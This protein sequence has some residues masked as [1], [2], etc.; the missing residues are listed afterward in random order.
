MHRYVP[1][2]LC[3][4]PLLFVSRKWM[5]FASAQPVWQ[6][7][8]KTP[9]FKETGIQ[10]R[11]AVCVHAC[12]RACECVW[13]QPIS[14]SDELLSVCRQ[15]AGE[16]APPIPQ[17]QLWKEWGR[18]E[19]P[20][21][22]YGSAGISP[23][24]WQGNPFFY[25][26]H[27]QLIPQE[28]WRGGR[29]G[30]NEDVREE[31]GVM[32]REGVSTAAGLKEGDHHRHRL[33]VTHLIQPVHQLFSALHVNECMFTRSHMFPQSIHEHRKR[34]QVLNLKMTGEDSSW[35]RFLRKGTTYES[36]SAHVWCQ[37]VP[38]ISKEALCVCVSN[39]P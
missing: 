39:L 2:V 24:P 27:V 16:S 9:C 20:A 7:R 38:F 3:C 11:Y 6:S 4:C 35:H 25:S 32:E 12:A 18:G 29:R 36:V 22:I 26:P 34:G 21:A 8:L 30:E 13:S 10:R 33:T 14:L 5:L 23:L 17:M 31:G 19:L 28:S 37:D 1:L 15:A